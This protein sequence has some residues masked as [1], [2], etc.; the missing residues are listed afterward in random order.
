LGADVTDYLQ[1]ETRMLPTQREAEA[2][3]RAGVRLIGDVD[4]LAARVARLRE[5]RDPK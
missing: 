5:R 1:R 2:L 3:A 4:R